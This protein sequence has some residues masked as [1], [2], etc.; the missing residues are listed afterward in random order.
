[1]A[2]SGSGDLRV[3]RPAARPSLAALVTGYLLLGAAATTIDTLIW[4]WAGLIATG[5]GGLLLLPV[6]VLIV[7]RR[8]RG[9]P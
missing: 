9:A 6:V 5:V 8:Q 3:P 1:M 7:R 2:S 4:G